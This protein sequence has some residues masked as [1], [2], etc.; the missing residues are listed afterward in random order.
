MTFQ[1]RLTFKCQNNQIHTCPNLRGSFFCFVWQIQNKFLFCFLRSC[2]C[3]DDQQKKKKIFTQLP[4]KEMDSDRNEILKQIND[5]WLFSGEIKHLIQIRCLIHKLTGETV[6]LVETRVWK[7][8]TTFDA[9]IEWIT[10]SHQVCGEI[11]TSMTTYIMRLYRQHIL[12]PF[13]CKTLC[14]A[15]N[16]QKHG[17]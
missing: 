13:N 11:R 3:R 14:F 6:R 2:D 5:L 7:T 9:E 1:K 16:E 12:I 4:Y 17:L 15:D 10:C 8:T